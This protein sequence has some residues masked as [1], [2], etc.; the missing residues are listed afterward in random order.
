MTVRVKGWR[1]TG[2]FA[3]R[4]LLV[5]LMAPFAGCGDNLADVSGIVTLDGQPLRGGGD[6]RATVIFQPASG[7]SVGAVGVVDEN[8]RYNLSTGSKD[9][10]PPGDYRVTCSATQ[11]VP[12]KEPGGTP[13]GRR[14]THR[15]YANANTSGLQFMVEP[16]SNEFNIPLESRPAESTAS[17]N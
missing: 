9:G 2:V 6:V 14:L 16:G 3:R 10:A 12:S 7:G 1:Q 15:K 17:A 4:L 8:G 11:L 5:L 13:G